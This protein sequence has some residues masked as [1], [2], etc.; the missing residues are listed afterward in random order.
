[1]Q[2]EEQHQYIFTM[3]GWEIFPIMLQ[4]SEALADELRAV[5]ADGLSHL[6]ANKWFEKAKERTFTYT[7]SD[8]SRINE[9]RALAF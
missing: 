9:M 3:E 8:K 5:L 4:A 6:P 1:M 7:T 2:I